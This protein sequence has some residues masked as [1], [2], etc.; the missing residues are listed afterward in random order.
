MEIPG[1]DARA[2]PWR[3]RAGGTEPLTLRAVRLLAG[4]G[5]MPS[6]SA[7][8]LPRVILVGEGG[9]GKSTILKQLLAQ[10]GSA[11]RIPVWVP[12]ASLPMNG[13]LTIASLVEHLVHQATSALGLGEVNAAFFEALVRDG[14][15]TLGFDALDEC[16]SLVRR[17]RVRGLIVDVAREWKRCQ[18][19]VTSRPEALRETPL[20][21]LALDK[22]QAEAIKS[23]EF[24]AFEPMPFT[25]EDIAPFLR[26]AFADGEKLAQELLDRTG[27]DAL[28]ENPLTLTLVGLVARSSKTGLPARRTPLF[29]QCLS[30]VCETWED[31]KGSGSSSDGLDAPQRMDVMRSLGWGAQCADGNVVSAIAARRLLAQVP[32]FAVPGRAQAIVNGLAQRNLLLRAETADEGALEVKSIRFAHPQF[33][34]YLAGAHFA[35]QFAVD[36][37]H[38]VAAMAPH[39]FDSGWLE[40]LRFAV[41]TAANDADLRD[42]LLR[43]ALTADD[44]YRDLLHR[45]EFLV[46]RL[47]APLAVAAPVTVTMVVD[48]LEQVAMAEPALRDE[49]VRTLLA[50]AP[51]SPAKPAIRRFAQGQGVA[52]AFLEVAGRPGTEAR[53]ESF[54]WRLRA[55]EALASAG[56]AV[57]AL[58]ALLA[59]P[60]HGIIST[61][62]VCDL[63][64]R[65]GDLDGA[66]AAWRQC[67]D[68]EGYNFRR[69]VG[70]SMDK[71]G[72]A[73]KFDAW[74]QACLARGLATVEDARLAQERRVEADYAGVW[75]RLFAAATKALQAMDA[76]NQFASSP[77]ADAVYAALDPQISGAKDLAA[78]RELVA[79][80][81]RHPAFT[82]FAGDRVRVL[83]PEL[84]A[85]TIH[86]LTRYALDESIS[87]RDHS[88]VRSAV[89]A[90]CDET[91]DALAVPA[92]LKLLRQF[93]P[94]ERWGSAVARS[95]ARRGQA[96]AGIRELQPTL[97]VPAGISDQ[98]PD[99]L[100][101]RRARAWRLARELHF[102]QTLALLDAMYRSGDVDA[103]AHRLMAVW[104]VSGVEAV[105]ADWFRDLL[106]VGADPAGRRL[107]QLLAT[108]AEDT[109]LADE[110]RQA[111]DGGDVDLAEAK[112]YPTPWTLANYESAFASALERGYFVGEHDQEETASI[113]NVTSLLSSMVTELDD[114]TALRYADAWVESTLND[115][116]LS[117][118]DKADHLASQL[119]SL[120]RWGLT[121]DRWLESAAGLARTV[122]PADRTGLIQWLNANA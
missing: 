107:M 64:A 78:R 50:L 102:A 91:D 17:Q 21:L 20:P 113:D 101:Q 23:V 93:D 96:A 37:A 106:R 81:L 108:H 27:I 15:L 118:A 95:L 44:P 46:A 29:A 86:Q 35:E 7:S 60:T 48:C 119:G 62:E 18:V 30:T 88:R 22:P 87:G 11:G 43:A 51:H 83:Y 25:R 56:D 120:S 111:L 77:V 24:L 28:L 99:G 63:R 13:P 3:H 100:D 41:A 55:I 68:C 31:A 26:G 79:A 53:M 39:W 4:K 103:D 110:A 114:G 38:A 115:G 36:T 33:R 104:N 47:L 2:I 14:R 121:S 75:G 109:R 66:L 90:V 58:Q 117:P 80:A 12:L 73:Q 40:V 72:Q 82:W 16:G 89:L 32:A 69:L 5:E 8:V 67:F 85:E 122:A 98:N 112:E 19:F 10:A 45:P 9:T 97:I 59:L 74:L 49:A 61:I 52:L 34:E 116:S 84:Q 70:Q 42:E 6:L 92:L 71:A 54:Q 65:L 57:T 1:D 76:D 94:S 105:A